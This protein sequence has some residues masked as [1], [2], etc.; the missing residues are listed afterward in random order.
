[1]LVLSPPATPQNPT[2]PHDLGN[3]VLIPQ[4]IPGVR[5][6]LIYLFPWVGREPT[7]LWPE[8]SLRRAGTAAPAF[9]E[10]LCRGT[11]RSQYYFST[12]LVLQPG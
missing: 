5:N 10:L 8:G 4:K 11:G 9:A 1:M 6:L 3:A 12:P 2:W 7:A